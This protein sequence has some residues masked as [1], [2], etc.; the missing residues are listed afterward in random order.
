MKS[1]VLHLSPE[2]VKFLVIN[3][4]YVY[5]YKIFIPFFSNENPAIIPTISERICTYWPLPETIMFYLWQALDSLESK[6]SCKSSFYYS[7]RH[8]FVPDSTRFLFSILS[9]RPNPILLKN[10]IHLRHSLFW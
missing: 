6:K 5:A 1:N 3:F 8:F 4:A 10:R 7:A 9:P 2:E